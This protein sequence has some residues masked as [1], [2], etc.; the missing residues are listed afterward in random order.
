MESPAPAL[1][2]VRGLRTLFSG[3]RGEVRAVDGVDLL[4]ERGRTLGIVGESGCGK[5]VT[6]LSIMGLV[7]QPPGRVGGEVLFEGEDLLKLSAQRLRDLRGD[8]LSMIFQEPMTSLNPA[9]TVGD[10]VAEALLRHRNISR[11]EAKN[12]AIEMLRRVRIPSPERRAGDYP[13]Q[14]S[15]GM[16]QRVMIAMALACNPKLLIADEPTTALDVTIQAQILEL[17]RALRAELGTSIILI[18]HDLGVIAEL[19]DDVIVMYAGQVIERCAVPRLFSEPQ[20]PYTVGLLGS[21]PRLDLDQERLSAI[22]GFVP[23]AAAMPAGCRFHPRCP[24]AVEKCFQEIP[25]LM[26]IKEDHYAAC[27]RAPL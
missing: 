12:Q 17:M 13:H 4:L 1:L 10:Q 7:P 20:H 3:E 6:A 22:E 8:Q 23:D 24:F 21:I 27:W 5:S 9:F 19:A 16:R 2:E 11:K 25:P 15:G 26:K 18:T 14:L